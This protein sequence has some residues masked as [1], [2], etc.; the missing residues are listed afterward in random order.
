VR[1]WYGSL[2]IYAASATLVG[3]G[4]LEDANI[5]EAQIHFSDEAAALLWLT[6]GKGPPRRVVW[7]SSGL[8]VGYG[9]VSERNQLDVD[10][11]QI[12]IRGR[13]PTHLSGAAGGVSIAG[14]DGRLTHT[15]PCTNP[16]PVD[17]TGPS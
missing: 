16:G 12:C 3:L 1:R 8:A 9:E 4:W 13:K 17:N 14:S 2:G 5:E 11:F 6:E 15:F 7:N 10:V